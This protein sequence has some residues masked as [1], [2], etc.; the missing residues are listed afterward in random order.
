ML[1][2]APAAVVAQ[3]AIALAGISQGVN[4]RFKQT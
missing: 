3:T 1:Q 4:R 2:V